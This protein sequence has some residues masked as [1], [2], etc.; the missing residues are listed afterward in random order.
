[1]TNTREAR[2][3]IL[4]YGALRIG[5]PWHR[6]RF[7]HTIG[8][9]RDRRLIPVMASMEGGGEESWPPSPPLQEL[10]IAEGPT[11]PNALLVGSAGGSHWSLVVDRDP[12][13]E[14]FRIDVACR[15]MNLPTA[16]S[17]QDA[18]RYSLHSHYR[19]MF[20]AE[21]LPG[22]PGAIAV[23][24]LVVEPHSN[25]T[26]AIPQKVAGAG[27][28]VGDLCLAPRIPNAASGTIRWQYTVGLRKP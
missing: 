7:A 18:Q 28:E 16:D 6:D 23:G 26:T 4:E 15:F 20:C 12:H 14:L 13:A 9:V 2:S 21:P 10:E 11:G 27:R 22:H 17:P 5:F 24:R 19:T 8:L 1:M 25:T 3:A